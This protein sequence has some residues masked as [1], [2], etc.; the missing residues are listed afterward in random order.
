MPDYVHREK[1]LAYLLRH[2][3][4]YAFEEYGWREVDELVKNH[5]FSQEELARIVE[6]SAKQ[7][8]EFSEDGQ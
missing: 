5:G 8:F 3:T 2:D 4:N 7:R 1:K 6:K